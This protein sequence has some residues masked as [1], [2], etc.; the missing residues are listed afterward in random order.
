[1]ADPLRQDIKQRLF[2]AA[3]RLEKGPGAAISQPEYDRLEK[4]VEDQCAVRHTGMTG[5]PE[6]IEAYCLEKT[7]ETV[8]LEA[9][10]PD[11]CLAIKQEHEQFLQIA[12]EARRGLGLAQVLM[13]KANK[14]RPELETYEALKRAYVKSVGEKIKTKMKEKKIG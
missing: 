9:I 11:F 7:L 2:D 5:D 10:C 13:Q 3:D 8:D 4:I 1:M 6:M 12:N 14:K